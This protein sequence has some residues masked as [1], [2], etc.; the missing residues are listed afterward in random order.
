[1]QYPMRA[2]LKIGSQFPDFELPDTY[3]KTRK[4]SNL[5]GGFPGVLTFIRGSF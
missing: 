3:K 5:L 1:M 2:D 4:L